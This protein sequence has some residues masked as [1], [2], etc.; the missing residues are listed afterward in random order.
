VFEN[1]DWQL[2]EPIMNVEVVV[3][4]EFQGGIVGMVSRRTGV[5]TGIDGTEFYSTVTSDVS[6]VVPSLVIM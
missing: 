2:L 5:I 6:T 1:G 3:P 4:S